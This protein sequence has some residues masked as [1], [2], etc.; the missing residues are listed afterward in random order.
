MKRITERCPGCGQP[1][2][3]LRYCARPDCGKPFRN[4]RRDAVYCSAGC[5]KVMAQRALRL[6]AQEAAS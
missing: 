1:V 4:R 6:R 3:P 5:A 2:P